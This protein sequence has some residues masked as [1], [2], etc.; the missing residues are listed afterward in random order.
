[1]IKLQTLEPY[2][3]NGLNKYQRII[4]K[5]GLHRMFEIGYYQKQAGTTKGYG[6]NY[7]SS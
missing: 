3:M 6:A 7:L 5:N 2:G 1:M 4:A